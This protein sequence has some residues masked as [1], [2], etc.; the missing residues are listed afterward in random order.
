MTLSANLR[1]VAK[2]IV[3]L[4]IGFLVTILQ[5]VNA[6][7]VDKA[8]VISALVTLLTSLSVWAVP[9]TPRPGATLSPRRR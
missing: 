9:N 5:A 8:T 6:G 1:S 2:A 4:V 7:T 3:P